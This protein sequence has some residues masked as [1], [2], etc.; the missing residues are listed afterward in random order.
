ML[1]IM[2]S[3]YQPFQV[4]ALGP[5]DAQPPAAP[6]LRDRGLEESRAAAFVCV[7]VACLAPT[8]DPRA[9]AAELSDP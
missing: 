9:R 1:N 2:R 8:T 7:S 6:L 3:G 5:P 4:V